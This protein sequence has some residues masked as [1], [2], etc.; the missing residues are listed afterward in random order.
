[1]MDLETSLNPP[2]AEYKATAYRP[3]KS[4]LYRQPG[5]GN[6]YRKGKHLARIV[7]TEEVLPRDTFNITPD[8]L[9]ECERDD[10]PGIKE[11]AANGTL[12]KEEQKILQQLLSVA[13]FAHIG[14][15]PLR[16][17]KLS[18]ALNSMYGGGRFLTFLFGGGLLF[19]FILTLF[20]DEPYNID[21]A[22]FA[23]IIISPPLSCWIA[24]FFIKKFKPELFHSTKD[25]RAWYLCRESGLVTQYHQKKKNVVLHEAPFSEMECYL[26]ST[27]LPSGLLRY[28]LVLAHYK[29]DWGIDLS[30]FYKPSELWQECAADWDSI[31]Y[32]MDVTQP[33][34]DDP[35]H[36]EFRHLD[37]TTAEYDKKTKRPPH[38]WRDMDMQTFEKL[39]RENDTKLRMRYNR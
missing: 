38:Y 4:L 25:Y 39:K 17:N 32:F 22:L 3:D 1:M 5:P 19:L 24:I 31:Q 7:P 8:T 10:E 16:Y 6:R 29:D 37:P 28:N 27:P 9:R 15:S 26:H 35:D 2:V 34:S 36:E 13:Q 14:I 11:K 30:D 33:L 21:D 23:L 20:S 18:Y 12:T